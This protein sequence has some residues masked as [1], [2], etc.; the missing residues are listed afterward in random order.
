M[1]LVWLLRSL[2]FWL[3]SLCLSHICCLEIAAGCL[4]FLALLYWN[5]MYL[6]R[7]EKANNRQMVQ[8]VAE[9]HLPHADTLS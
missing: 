1:T 9:Y 5:V 4:F 6:G 3:Q 7:Y 2:F 8:S